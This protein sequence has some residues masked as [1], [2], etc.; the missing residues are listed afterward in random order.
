MSYNA[1][2]WISFCSEVG[3]LDAQG[4]LMQ[5][6]SYDAWGRRRDPATWEYYPALA[7]AT[8]LHDRCFTG[9]EHIDLFD[10]VNMDGRIYDPVLGRFLSPDPIVQ[11]P[12]FA[13]GL[14]RYLYCLDNPLSLTDPSGYSCFSKHWK[15]LLGA[16]VGIAA[17]AFTGGTSL[18][19]TNAGVA[20]MVSGAVGGA[21]GALVGSI[22]N[23]SNLWQTVKSTITGGLIGGVLGVLNY[24]SGSGGLEERPFKHVIIDATMSGLQ[25]GNV[26]HGAMTGVVNCL[27]GYALSRYGRAIGEPGELAI[28][29]IA[30]GT[31]AEIGGG[32]FAN[33]PSPPLSHTS[34]TLWPTA[35]Q[36]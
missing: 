32:K 8:P 17:A 35:G 9:H 28:M 7:D 31:V 14:N 6:L 27:G 13:M 4:A 3:Y 5:E 15:T 12:D 25:G 26:F 11:L 18:G 36:C 2:F 16:V 22:L 20:S 33:G 30:G 24:A 1:T 10:M 34:S 21:S 23:G 29:A 19:I